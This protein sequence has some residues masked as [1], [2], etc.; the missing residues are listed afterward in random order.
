MIDTESYVMKE[1]REVKEKGRRRQY[2]TKDRLSCKI[3]HDLVIIL[4]KLLLII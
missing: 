2:R 3:L 1:L 4:N